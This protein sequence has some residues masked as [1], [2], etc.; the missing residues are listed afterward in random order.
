MLDIEQVARSRLLDFIS[1]RK[2]AIP[3]DS[4]LLSADLTKLGF[5]VI[6]WGTLIGE[7]QCDC[8]TLIDWDSLDAEFTCLQQVVDQIKSGT[9]VDSAIELHNRM[10]RD[11][12]LD[13]QIH[14]I[15]TARE[16]DWPR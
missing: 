14:D 11:M 12:P 2:I 16:L 13:D 1:F 7:I 6:D 10:R 4:D 5:T 3:L 9:A 15:K 8:L